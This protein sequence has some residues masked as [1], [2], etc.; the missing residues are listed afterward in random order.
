MVIDVSYPSKKQE[1]EEPKG[2]S[3]AEQVQQ[4]LPHARVVKGLEPHPRPT[5]DGPRGG[6]SRR[7]V[8]IAGDDP[9]AKQVVFALART[10]GSIPSTPGP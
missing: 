5:P 10:C 1:R 4:R 2:S 9:E 6:R 8:L 7:S 3:T